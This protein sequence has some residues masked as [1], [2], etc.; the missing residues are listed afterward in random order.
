MGAGTEGTERG[1]GIGG[2]VGGWVGVA[3]CGAHREQRLR[4]Q[5]LE[6][7]WVGGREFAPERADGPQVLENV[8]AEGH[9]FPP[10]LER[11]T[12]QGER[13]VVQRKH[14]GGRLLFFVFGTD[15]TMIHLP[16]MMA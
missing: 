3:I 1:G 11:E 8:V 9:V 2:C 16:W 13:G 12:S 14:D 5:F 6:T 15:A 7:G 4:G 10:G